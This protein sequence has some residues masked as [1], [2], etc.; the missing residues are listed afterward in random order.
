LN[1]KAR[2]R[3][4]QEHAALMAEIWGQRN[5][6]PQKSKFRQFVDSLFGRGKEVE[7]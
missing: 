4:E 3:R 2:E 7:K 6:P 1:T 5:Q